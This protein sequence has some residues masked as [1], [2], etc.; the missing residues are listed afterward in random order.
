MV[1]LP[2]LAAAVN[3]GRRRP[4]FCVAAATTAAS[5]DDMRRPHRPHSEMKPFEPPRRSPDGRNILYFLETL[6]IDDITHFDD[7]FVVDTATGIS[8]NLTKEG[9]R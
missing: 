1:M 9:D 8:M 7:I 5:E 2:R 6:F 4:Y 3:A